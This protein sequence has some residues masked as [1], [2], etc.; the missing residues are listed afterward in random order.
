MLPNTKNIL[1]FGAFVALGGLAVAGWVRKNDRSVVNPVVAMQPDPYA[2]PNS[3]Q[4]VAGTYAQPQQGYPQQ[5][6]PQQGYQQQGYAQQSYAQGTRQP[7]YT[8]DGYYPSRARPVYIRQQ[9]AYVDQPASVQ[10]REVVQQEY[11]TDTRGRRRSRSKA[12]SVE[13]VAG[14]AA[15][16]AVIGALAGGGKGAAIGGASGAGAGFL[17]DRLTHNH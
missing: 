12:H 2:A 11:Y 9:P 10:R 15:A 7:V 5:N 17:Y 16:G 4:P 6:Y 13:I 8:S 14:T 1:I 3:A